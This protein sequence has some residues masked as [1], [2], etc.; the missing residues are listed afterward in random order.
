MRSKEEL[1]KIYDWVRH[2]DMFT[3]EEWA[4]ISNLHS[5]IVG[6]NAGGC[7]GCGSGMRE[8]KYRLQSHLVVMIEHMPD[9]KPFVWP[10]MEPQVGVSKSKL[11]S[12]D[13]VDKAKKNVKNYTKNK[14]K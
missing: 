1:I 9:P 5:E 4:T 14:R 2:N 11:E 13:V 12:S 7:L 3:K 8:A 10:K 6:G